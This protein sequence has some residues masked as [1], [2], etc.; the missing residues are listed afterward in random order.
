M[1]STQPKGFF[2]QLKTQFEDYLNDRLLLLKLEAAEKTAR[3][4]AALATGLIIGLLFFFV[5][6]FIS[7]M[8]GYFFSQ[9]TGSLFTGYAIVAGIYLVALVLLILFGRKRISASIINFVIRIL[10]AADNEK[11][12]TDA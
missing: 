6:L 12:D 10:F 3:L 9:L 1:E 8:A 7:L 2:R 4:V 5:L 11:E